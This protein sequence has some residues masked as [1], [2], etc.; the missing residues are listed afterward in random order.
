MAIGAINRFQQQWSASWPRH[1][2]GR[3]RRHSPGR[4]HQP[5]LTTIHQPI[6]D[7]GRQV[8]AMLIAL[9]NGL[10]PDPAHILLEPTLVIRESS[11]S[12]LAPP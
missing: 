10:T 8:C 1:R 5:P 7:I 12:P 9:I 11:G 4:L 3:F 6:Y 2:P